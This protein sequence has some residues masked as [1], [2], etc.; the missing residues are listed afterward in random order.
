[1]TNETTGPESTSSDRELTWRARDMKYSSKYKCLVSWELRGL[2]QGV[3]WCF[4]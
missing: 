2:V 1:M 3:E 4:S